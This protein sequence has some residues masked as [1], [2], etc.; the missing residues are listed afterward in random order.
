MNPRMD[1]KGEEGFLE[2]FSLFSSA[3]W[4]SRMKGFSDRVEGSQLLE[5]VNHNQ[6]SLLAVIEE[7]Q[8]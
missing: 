4:A 5:H 7:L 6:A 8:F 1:Y 3:V 2:E